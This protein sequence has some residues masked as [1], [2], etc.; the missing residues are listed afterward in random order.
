[1]A[2]SCSSFVNN[3]IKKKKQKP[4]QPHH[5]QQRITF[6]RIQS[7]HSDYLF[8]FQSQQF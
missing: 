2:N 3:K 1:M 7:M 8:F 5:W 6:R 4:N